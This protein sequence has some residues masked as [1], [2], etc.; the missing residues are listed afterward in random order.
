MAEELDFVEEELDL[1]GE[2]DT[3]RRFKPLISKERHQ[4]TAFIDEL[5]KSLT[6]WSLRAKEDALA[7]HLLDVHLP[8]ILRL[9]CTCPFSD[10]RERC[11]H[12][13]QDVQVRIYYLMLHIN[14][15]MLDERDY[16][17]TTSI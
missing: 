17:T 2:D 15:I 3:L 8:T 7:Q 5:Q 14:Y 10:V 6:M 11:G 13:L 12:L 4:R 9:S 16:S 1:E